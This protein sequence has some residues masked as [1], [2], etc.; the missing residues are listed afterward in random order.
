MD[1]LCR[2]CR[3]IYLCLIESGDL[4]LCLGDRFVLELPFRTIVV[5]LHLLFGLERFDE[6]GA[7][8]VFHRLPSVLRT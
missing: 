2:S 1:S 7:V 6:L 4:L 5:V 8:E 3:Y